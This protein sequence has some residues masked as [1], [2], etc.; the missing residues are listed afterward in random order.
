MCV[1]I[2]V[3]A[4]PDLLLVAHNSWDSVKGARDS[5]YCR[6]PRLKLLA[7][8]QIVYYYH[9]ERA[10]YSTNSQYVSKM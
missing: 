9:F 5:S 2:E 3:T 7:Q 6:L 4:V 1:Y 10:P 8:T